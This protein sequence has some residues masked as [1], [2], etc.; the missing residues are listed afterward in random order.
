VLCKDLEH[1]LATPNR[2][3]ETLL[4]CFASLAGINKHKFRLLQQLLATTDPE[5]DVPHINKK[6]GANNYQIYTLK[7]LNMINMNKSDQ[8]Q[9]EV[10]NKVNGDQLKTVE[11]KWK[12]EKDWKQDKQLFKMF[13]GQSWESL[14]LPNECEWLEAADGPELEED[15]EYDIVVGVTQWPNYLYRER[16][17]PTHQN[18]SSSQNSQVAQFYTSNENSDIGT[19][20]NYRSQGMGNDKQKSHMM[21]CPKRK[22]LS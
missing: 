7:D 3:I 6:A 9:E 16:K 10:K 17:G 14:W 21:P 8:H 19:K 4:P 1:W 20:R 15:N 5:N 11:S 12:L 13:Y 22:R 2:L 18:P